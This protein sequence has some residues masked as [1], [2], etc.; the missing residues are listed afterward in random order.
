[1]NERKLLVVKPGLTYPELSYT[2]LYLP[3][4]Y[5][6]ILWSQNGSKKRPNP[7]KNIDVAVLVKQRG[8]CAVGALWVRGGDGN[9][10]TTVSLWIGKRLR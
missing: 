1:M 10:L 4:L 8:G 7:L 5:L 2:F 9:A 6:P 3:I